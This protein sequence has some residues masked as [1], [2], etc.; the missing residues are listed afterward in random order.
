MSGGLRFLGTYIFV[1]MVRFLSLVMSIPI[2]YTLEPHNLHL[3]SFSM[4]W[5]L[6]SETSTVLNNYIMKS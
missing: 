4:H 6:L 1:P 2:K 5:K 3:W